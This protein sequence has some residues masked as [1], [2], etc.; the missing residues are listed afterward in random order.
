MYQNISNAVNGK[1][2]IKYKLE[3]GYPITLPPFFTG[4]TCIGQHWISKISEDNADK[5]GKDYVYVMQRFSDGVT[6]DADDDML[7]E[8]VEEHLSVN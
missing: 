5:K 1:L 6:D 8:D 3:I 7:E 2:A 4:T